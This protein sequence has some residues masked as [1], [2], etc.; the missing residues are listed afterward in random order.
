[1]LT[2]P[3]I[4]AK[5]V[6]GGRSKISSS[7]SFGSLDDLEIGETNGVE[8]RL[9]QGAPSCP[10]SRSRSSGSL[11]VIE[12]KQSAE[13]IAAL[14]RTYSVLIHRRHHETAPETLV[15][16]LKIVVSDVFAHR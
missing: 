12:A 7:D 13:S 3:K 4:K 1:M 10:E 14:D 11:P 8:I 9:F 16:P 5:C 6:V 15:R 2:T